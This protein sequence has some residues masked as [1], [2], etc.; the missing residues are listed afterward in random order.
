MMLALVE[1]LMLRCLLL[2]V[3]LLSP[4]LF[5]EDLIKD[6]RFNDC[7]LG[8]DHDEKLKA[9]KGFRNGE[10]PLFLPVRNAAQLSWISTKDYISRVFE[11]NGFNVMLRSS[12]ELRFLPNT[13]SGQDILIVARSDS[14]L[15]DRRVRDLVNVARFKDIS[16]STLWLGGG[17]SSTLRDLAKGSGGSYI[18]GMTIL[19]DA[20]QS[21]MDLG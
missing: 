12:Q 16:V 15:N 17:D 3:L 5:A 18:S 13:L 11:M 14:A 7:R 6:S 2:F 10:V 19:K 4:S 8:A 20:C 1:V 9:I 21:K